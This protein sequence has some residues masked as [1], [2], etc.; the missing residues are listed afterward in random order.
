MSARYTGSLLIFAGLMANPYFIGFY[1]TNGSINSIAGKFAII[2]LEL[3]IIFCGILVLWRKPKFS[4]NVGLSLTVFF[5]CL[6]L[7][8]FVS[9]S[10]NFF[11]PHG[12][13][14]RH[15]LFYGFYQPDGELG[16]RLRSD[17]RGYKIS[18]MEE[19]ISGV[20]STDDH[21]FRNVGRDYS[22]ANKYF[23]GDSFVFG[24]WVDRN[25]T[26]Y[27]I[28]ES[29]LKEPIITLGVGG[30]GFKQYVTLMNNF[31]HRYH[32]D[33]IVLGIFA[34][35]LKKLPSESDLNDHYNKEGWN[36]YES[37]SPPYKEKSLITQMIKIIGKEVN[38]RKLTN[39]LFLYKRR[40]ANPNYIAAS[41][42][43]EVETAFLDIVDL[44]K[45]NNIR[46]I[47]VLFPSK[48]SAYKSKYLKLFPGNYLENE[49]EGYTRICKIADK[50]GIECVDLTPMFRARANKG[51]KLYFDK[52][53]HWNELGNK[54]VSGA[55]LPYL[56]K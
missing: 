50:Q 44:A 38:S 21:G 28:I 39:G 24:A 49:E 15:D 25:K 8:E 20:Y 53:P 10:M 26:F 6:L 45:Q 55:I 41:Q 35:D 36:A 43:V 13:K 32:P 4:A 34:N 31:V 47:V 7:A 40:G 30:Y 29:A 37:E 2:V 11:A 1:T 14:E 5:L 12:Y 17:L 18:W 54:I 19:N 51:E 56:T 33:T 42:Y 22:T 48:E 16:Y 3:T 23:I 9:V 27:G 46:L 52:D